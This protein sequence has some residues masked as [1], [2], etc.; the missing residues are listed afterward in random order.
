MF[1]RECLAPTVGDEMRERKFSSFSSLFTLSSNTNIQ[2]KSPTPLYSSP[3]SFYLDLYGKCAFDDA[4]DRVLQG[5]YFSSE[6]M[7][8]EMCLSI[9]RDKGFHYSGLQWQI[10]CYCGNEPVNG[11]EWSWLRIP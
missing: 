3:Y 6:T 11:F 8:V 9:C 4:S 1:G 7:T 5:H 2:T 10:E